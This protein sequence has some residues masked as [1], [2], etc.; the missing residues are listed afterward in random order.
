MKL[1]Y[2]GFILHKNSEYFP[3]CAD[4]IAYKHYDSNKLIKFAIADGISKSF[5]PK[6]WSRNLVDEYVLYESIDYDF[7]KI[8]ESAQQK[9]ENEFKSYIQALRASGGQFTDTLLSLLRF[10]YAGSTLAG[11]EIY[12]KDDNWYWRS[13]VLGD[14]L[15]MFFPS[16]FDHTRQICTSLKKTAENNYIFDNYPD[17][18]RSRAQILDNDDNYQTIDVTAR[19]L[20]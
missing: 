2:K 6:I 13:S 4:N 17:Y 8:A 16:D 20:S 15:V 5:L 11:L 18:F 3:D 12:K 1:E 10:G 7:V 9:W 14:S 19:P